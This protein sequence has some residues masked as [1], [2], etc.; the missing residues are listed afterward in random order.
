MILAG[1]IAWLAGLVAWYVIRW[2]HHRRSRRVPVAVRRDR[3]LEVALLA[4]SFAGLFPVPLAWVAFGWPAWADYVPGVWQIPAG[5]VVLVLAMALFQRTHRDLGRNW[6][7]ALE[8]REGHVLVTTGVYARIRHPMYAAFWLWALAQALLLGNFVA[9]LAG[10]VGFG[11]LYAARVGR[12]E[13][14]LE[15]AF[16]DAYR[17]YRA[18]TRRLWWR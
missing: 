10:L 13:R 5:V 1:Q 16:G 9:G 14:L 2:P 4:W 18:R 6:S 11:T 3:G 12:E 8:V 7:V 15:A 17:A